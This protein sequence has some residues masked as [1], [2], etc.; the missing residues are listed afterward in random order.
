MWP[1]SF[2]EHGASLEMAGRCPLVLRPPAAGEE[3]RVPP[4]LQRL[5]EAMGL[6]GL[7][8]V[9][10]LWRFCSGWNYYF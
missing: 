8:G 4:E 6:L 3:G 5:M 9:W 2:T 10:C 7:Q 1:C